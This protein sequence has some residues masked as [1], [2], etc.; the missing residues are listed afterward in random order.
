[1]STNGNVGSERKGRRAQVY[2]AAEIATP[3]GVM[4]AKIRDISPKGAHI[5]SDHELK[6]GSI[7]ELRRGALAEAARVV[8]VRGKEAGLLFDQPL[9]RALLEDTLPKSLLLM[10]D[11]D[12]AAG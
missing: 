3:I 5:A 1:M 10:L 4:K 9:S 2:M 11:L 6:S 7:V 8:W 12:G